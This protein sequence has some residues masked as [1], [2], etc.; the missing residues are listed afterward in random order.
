MYACM[1][2]VSVKHGVGVYPFF[3]ECCFRVRVS[4]KVRLGLF[5]VRVKLTVR[6][7]LGFF[8]VRVKVN[9]N[10]NPKNGIL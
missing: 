9:V 3:K 5:R 2:R 7:R 1:S 8:R 10:P 6:V 4:F